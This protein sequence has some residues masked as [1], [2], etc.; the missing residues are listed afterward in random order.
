MKL[1]AYQ[2]ALIDSSFQLVNVD[3]SN[4]P[5]SGLGSGCLFEHHGRKI[6]LTVAHIKKK[7]RTLIA[8]IRFE[9]SNGTLVIPLNNPIPGGL[10]HASKRLRKEAKDFCYLEVPPTLE[11]YNQIIRDY[12]SAIL[13]EMPVTI[14]ELSEI[15]PPDKNVSYGFCGR[16]DPNLAYH[17]GTPYFETT[18]TP[19]QGLTYIGE[20][21]GLFVFQLPMQHPGH[22]AFKGC[23]GTPIIGEDSSVVAL[24]QGGDENSDLIYGIPL[25]KYKSKLQ[26]EFG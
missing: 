10:I 17:F 9:P 14:F 13:K 18:R 23:S 26:I 8:Q 12:D 7:N 11:P 16:V 6:L 3:S 20:D 4:I 24:V 1:T 15:Q 25:I 22:E 5:D 19:Y 2:E 21:D